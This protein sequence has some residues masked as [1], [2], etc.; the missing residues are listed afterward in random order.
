MASKGTNNDGGKSLYNILSSVKRGGEKATNALLHT[1]ITYQK[2]GMTKRGMKKP[3]QLGVKKKITPRNHV[4]GEN[5]QR[6]GNESSQLRGNGKSQN[7]LVP[8]TEGISIENVSK[9]Q[10]TTRNE[11]VRR[12][13][14]HLTPFQFPG[15][16][17]NYDSSRIKNKGGTSDK[18]K[19]KQHHV[20]FKTL[21]GEKSGC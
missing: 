3:F 12:K 5:L 15:R 11:R 20:T 9:K 13:G 6:G 1:S 4:K 8:K 2:D 14:Q 10:G 18:G 19:K 16:E 21:T 7:N 17:G